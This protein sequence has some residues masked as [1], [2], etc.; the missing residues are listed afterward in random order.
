MNNKE[1][2]NFYIEERQDVIIWMAGEVDLE[3]LDEVVIF[4]TNEIK[5]KYQTDILRLRDQEN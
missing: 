3:I 4:I 5:Q 1:E 2:I